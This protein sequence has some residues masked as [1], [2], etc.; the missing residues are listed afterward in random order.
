MRQDVVRGEVVTKKNNLA[1]G[2]ISSVI[3]LTGESGTGSIAVSFPFEVIMKIAEIMLPSHASKN[4]EMIEDLCGEIGSL[5]ASIIKT[6]LQNKGIELNASK[7]AVYA[8]QPHYLGH[9]LQKSVAF[10]PFSSDI[11]IIFVEICFGSLK[12]YKPRLAG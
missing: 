1:F 12:V 3:T 7:P 2:E 6:E 10:V 4:G 8:G 11:G 9:A 5:F